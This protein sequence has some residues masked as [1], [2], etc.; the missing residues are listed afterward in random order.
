MTSLPGLSEGYV[1][2][3]ES[4]DITGMYNLKSLQHLRL[5]TLPDPRLLEM[6]LSQLPNLIKLE[7]LFGSCLDRN[8]F[9]A[10]DDQF[11]FKFCRRLKELKIKVDV[12]IS[13]QEW[14]NGLLQNLKH[15][16]GLEALE[17]KTLRERTI[18][19]E[20][21]KLLIEGFDSFKYLR[22]LNLTLS[23]SRTSLVFG[24]EIDKE[25]A[26]MSKEVENMVRR[27]IVRNKRLEE[28]KICSFREF[29]FEWR[30]Y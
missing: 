20:M 30:K 7:V 28:I 16:T 24:S 26:K 1:Y 12:P 17:I 19:M 11:P 21:L 5:A 29:Y 22:R 14:G 2:K 6:A 27:L 25:K 18:S 23:T 4:P 9:E 10:W 8:P 3:L 13:A 15:L